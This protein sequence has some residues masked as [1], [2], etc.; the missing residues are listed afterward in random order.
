MSDRF[1]IPLSRDS[2]IAKRQEYNQ[3]VLVFEEPSLLVYFLG[4]KVGVKCA[5]VEVQ[6]RLVRFEAAGRGKP[7]GLLL[8][9]DDKTRWLLIRNW[10]V[11]TKK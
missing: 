6:G 1:C 7:G 9:G 10:V 11:I 3:D 8:V 4:R 5:D 2:A